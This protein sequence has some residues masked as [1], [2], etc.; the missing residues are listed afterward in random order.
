[1]KNAKGRPTPKESAANFSIANIIQYKTDAVKR[2]FSKI[3]PVHKMF[4]NFLLLTA[5]KLQKT[6]EKLAKI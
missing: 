6:M 1:V 5:K 2:I 3:P 4:T